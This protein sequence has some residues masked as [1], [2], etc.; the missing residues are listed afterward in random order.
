M[1][2]ITEL[3]SIITPVKYGYGKT[4]DKESF[5]LIFKGRP[6]KIGPF[7]ISKENVFS[8]EKSDYRYRNYSNEQHMTFFIFEDKTSQYFHFQNSAKSDKNSAYGRDQGDWVY[9]DVDMEKAI[10]FLIEGLKLNEE[11]LIKACIKFACHGGNKDSTFN[12]FKKYMKKALKEK[13]LD[14]VL[15]IVNNDTFSHTHISSY[16]LN[17]FKQFL[18]LIRDNFED[19]HEKVLKF[20]K[21]LKTKTDQY[22]KEGTKNGAWFKDYLVSI[23]DQKEEIVFTLPH[24]SK[25]E[26]TEKFYIKH[27]VVNEYFFE[28]GQTSIYRALIKK[29]IPTVVF[30]DDCFFVSANTKS[31]LDSTLSKFEKIL[32]FILEEVKPFSIQKR[33]RYVQEK[34]VQM[35][36]EQ[37]NILAENILLNSKVNEN[38]VSTPKKKVKI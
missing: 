29:I 31:E 38:E 13:S 22:F 19:E 35:P 7:S 12:A 16:H 37:F 24:Q 5:E 30:T 20:V 17:G 18:Y 34:Y 9:F 2:K 23:G 1:D 6:N 36:N 14:F 3:Q 4:F 32:T 21:T 27:D 33:L 8:I 25:H 11:E 26:V 28:K 15:N 10:P